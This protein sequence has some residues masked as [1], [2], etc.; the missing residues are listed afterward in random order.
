MAISAYSFREA[1]LGVE[2]AYWTKQG[3]DVAGRAGSD[4]GWHKSST[5]EESNCVE[6]AITHSSVLI[7]NSRD[8]SGNVL[9]FTHGEWDAFLAGVRNNEFSLEGPASSA[10]T[11][12]VPTAR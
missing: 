7:R 10:G 3:N 1:G 9:S 12:S 11:G 5:S 8:R 4:Q 2:V 6:V